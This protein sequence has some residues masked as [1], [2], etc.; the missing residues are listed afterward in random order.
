VAGDLSAGAELRGGG[1]AGAGEQREEEAEA[2][3][4]ARF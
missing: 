4:R 3:H 2:E 1:E